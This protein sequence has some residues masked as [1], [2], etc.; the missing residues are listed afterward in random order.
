MSNRAQF[1]KGFATFNGTSLVEAEHTW[2]LYS[3]GLEPGERTQAEE[4][5]YRM[6]YAS[7]E[8][9]AHIFR[10]TDAQERDSKTILRFPSA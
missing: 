3:V 10:D 7:A 9:Y 8:L 6:G 2:L 1:I 5:G 4:M